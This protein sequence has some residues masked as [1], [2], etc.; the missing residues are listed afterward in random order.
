MTPSRVLASLSVDQTPMWYEPGASSD[1][2]RRTYHL[3]Y[4][5][6]AGRAVWMRSDVASP[7]LAQVVTAMEAAL[8]RLLFDGVRE[9]SAVVVLAGGGQLSNPLVTSN[10]TLKTYRRTVCV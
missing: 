2:L 5:A 9:A 3:R 6:D 8:D 7:L 4:Y 1:L 10:I